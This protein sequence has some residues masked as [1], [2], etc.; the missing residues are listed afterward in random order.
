MS[1]HR[2][3]EF[4]RRREETMKEMHQTAS[5]SDFSDLLEA[6]NAATLG[7]TAAP[8]PHTPIRLSRGSGYAPSQDDD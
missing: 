3:R 2:I 6:N 1:A 8:A 4:M 7:S 5:A